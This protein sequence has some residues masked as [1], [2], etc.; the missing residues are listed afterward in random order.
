MQRQTTRETILEVAGRLFSELGYHSTP[1]SAIADEL[2]ITKAALYY[3]FPAKD[4]LLIALVQPF[5]DHRE[6]V[7]EELG[8]LSGST[9]N[10]RRAL[11]AYLE[12]EFSEERVLRMIM[13]DVTVLTHPRIRD[14]LVKQTQRWIDLIAGPGAELHDRVR[15]SAAMAAVQASVYNF[16]GTSLG[17]IRDTVFA[18]A[19]AAL[20][21]SPA[22]LPV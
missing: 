6:R 18:A 12:T 21:S 9:D 8:T 10:R 17:E 5:I 4:D 7:L 14:V 2:R 22:G 15:A 1:L 19:L 3:H 16:P 13:R 11:Q 20:D